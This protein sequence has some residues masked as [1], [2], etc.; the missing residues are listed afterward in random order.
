MQ[1]G[2]FIFPTEYSIRIDELARALEERG[3]ESLFV[4]EHTHIPASRRTP[5]PGGGP[6]PK[7][8]SHTLDPFV[9]LA[10]AAAVTSRLRLGTGICLVIQHDPIVTAKEV[11]S[12]DFLSNGRFLFGVGAGWN[13]EEIE[14]HG[15]AFP[16]RFRVM[17]ERVLAMKEIWTKEEA[18]FHGEFVRFD[19]IWSYPKP[20]QKPHPPVLLG[21][22]GA[23]HA[24]ARRRV[25]RRLVPA[26]AR[27]RRRGPG[28]A[29]RS[30][31]PR[32]APGAGPEDH[33]GLRVRR[34]GRP[35][36]PSTGT[37]RP[38]S[39]ASSSRCPPRDGSASCLS[40]TST[41]P[42]SAR[43]PASTEWRQ[44]ARVTGGIDPPARTGRRA[45]LFPQHRQAVAPG[46]PR[47]VGYRADDSKPGKALQNPR[48][49]P[50][51]FPGQG[52]PWPPALRRVG[53]QDLGP[54][55]TPVAF[56]RAEI[57]R[58]GGTKERAGA[59]KRDADSV[60]SA[61]DQACRKRASAA[62]AS[63]ALPC[64]WRLR[65]S[66]KSDHPLPGFR[67]RSSRYTASASTGRPPASRTAPSDCRT[68]KYQGGGSVNQCPSCSATAARRRLTARSV[69]PDR[70][71][72]SPARTFSA[73][74]S[75]A[76][77]LKKPA[78][79]RSAGTL[80]T[81]W[82]RAASSASASA[83]RPVAANARPRA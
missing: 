6:L 63:A 10:A 39:T 54:A 1:I 62:A 17:R 12:L 68:G 59:Q 75:M 67:L 16:T 19:R 11:A 9:G 79:A 18:E 64:A 66:P 23:A 31:G 71:A 22:E 13:V 38:G 28:P 47:R 76:F 25:L 44:P 4:T 26:G 78:S 81:I 49:E 32:R 35:C 15:T 52:P 80:A 61:R 60:T 69:W 43:R 45:D 7:E 5:W 8:Y 46:P 34:Q 72:I 30:P 82:R 27:G 65:A 73:S 55:S 37:G 20:V 24:P 29:R 36:P 51:R 33:L 2:A 57:G 74:S 48:P 56:R 40:S 3:L 41:P 42:S 77:V 21:G 53:D 50:R 14:H 58:G 70:A 83:R